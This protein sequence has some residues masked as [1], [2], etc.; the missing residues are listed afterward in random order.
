MLVMLA[1]PGM[2]LSGFKPAEWHLVSSAG[3]SFAN[4]SADCSRAVTAVLEV[5]P[6]TV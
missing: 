4:F 1:F 2:F 6:L 3:F 5:K